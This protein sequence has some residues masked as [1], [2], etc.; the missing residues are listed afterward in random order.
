MNYTKVSRAASLRSAR[1]AADIQTLINNR[2]Y[3]KFQYTPLTGPLPGLSFE[4]QTEDAINDIGNMSYGSYE[5]ATQ[6]LTTANQ[7]YNAAQ[8]AIEI[9][10]HAETTAQN[11]QTTANNAAT[12]A[13][14]AQTAAD[15]AATAA[16]N[17]Q[18]TADNAATAAANAQETADNAQASANTAIA[19]ATTAQT[20]A[21]NAQNDATS[22][23][24]RLDSL[25]P[26]VEELR[27]YDN[28]DTAVDLND[29]TEFARELLEA[30]NNTNAPETGSGWLDVDDDFNETYIRQK[31]MGQASGKTYVRFGTIVPDSDPVEVSEWTAWVEYAVKTDLDSTTTELT[32][33]I[34]TVAN[35][36]ATHE[37]N[38]NNP[39]KVTAEQLGLT[40]VYQYK[41]SV[42]TY[43]DLPTS[44]Q[45]IGD[46]YNIETADPD[47]GIKAGDNV[48]WDGTQWDILGGNHDLSG[49]ATLAGDNDFAG[50]NTFGASTIFNGITQVKNYLFVRNSTNPAGA[51][52]RIVLG[53]APDTASGMTKIE[54]LATGKLT[55]S[56]LPN[57][58]HEF[59]VGDYSVFSIGGNNTSST[60]TL[61]GKSLAESNA[62]GIALKNI[63]TPTADSD[64]ANKKYVDDAVSGGGGGGGGDV[65][66]AGN[67][68]FTGSNVFENDLRVTS[69]ASGS[70]DVGGILTLGYRGGGVTQSRI[71]SNANGAMTYLAGNGTTHTFSTDT[72][73]GIA[74]NLVTISGTEL[75]AKL[76]LANNSANII[77]TSSS[78][79]IESPTGNIYLNPTT[80]NTKGTLRLVGT[81]TG[82]AYAMHFN[83]NELQLNKN[84]DFNGFGDNTA[85]KFNNNTIINYSNAF[86]NLSIKAMGDD[87]ILE[88]GVAQ[89]A[90]NIQLPNNNGDVRIA[91]RLYVGNKNGVG[92]G[93]IS[94]E[95][96]EQCLYFMGTAENTYYAT[97]NTGNTISYQ[98]S[99]NCY[100]INCSIN[101]PSSLNMNFSGMNFKATV[102]SIPYMCKTLT[103]WLAV[104]ATVPT[105]A[106]TFPTGS[107]VYYPKGVAPALTANANNIINVIAI[108]DDTG[109]FSIQV[110]DSV[111]LPFSG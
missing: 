55:Y 12:A 11:A 65:T 71:S 39:H 5:I 9:A 108:V 105:V 101:D 62:S 6:A 96:S 70:E 99:A 79:T 69:G 32:A 16:A 87:N 85:I 95:N 67:N 31:F 80:A 60:L 49:Y 111:A 103:F 66:A 109:S 1:I 36:L 50:T 44:G 52:G 19:T 61:G 74:G 84:G 42:A 45:K 4:Q 40:T 18:T 10:N 28:I 53:Y 20:T 98:A 51:A 46:V 22:A 81:E 24:N 38:Y 37:A 34:T 76:A 90:W 59:L 110:C 72:S 21:D 73:G 57:L 17:A 33:R 88:L 82:N 2:S 102:G 47:H 91:N 25:T 54:A 27:Y 56:T 92:A 3:Y 29:K 41:G 48:A 97:P 77:S 107:A 89:G 13:A 58:S 35:K 75:S 7:A 15:N 83:G 23:L 100:L 106:W 26:V 86:K 63:L 43:A 8:S 94:S 64:A 78:L 104:G 68:I 30:S 14:N 93:V